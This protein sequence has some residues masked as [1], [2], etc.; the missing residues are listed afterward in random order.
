MRDAPTRT[1]TATSLAGV[2]VVLALVGWGIGAIIVGAG[3]RFDA[4][5]VNGL[6]ASPHTTV[7]SLARDAT[8]LGSP[9]WLDVVF[10]LAAALL[11]VRRQL[12]AVLFLV[13]ASPATV[14]LHA[15]IVRL[16]NR[17]RPLGPHLSSASGASFPSGHTMDST[18]LYLGLALILVG[19]LRRGPAGP[20]TAGRPRSPLER[21]LHGLVLLLLAA[22]GV[23]R[24]V[25]GVHYPSDVLAG[26]L[27]AGAWLGALVHF[28]RGLAD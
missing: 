15:V 11:L 20:P 2:W 6:R 8:F 1:R 5:V 9:L 27:I 24:V 25:V 16:V 14:A 19:V 3:S 21:I 22:I 13:L 23:S 7:L 12:R 26:W 10:L 28:A 4:S 18:G 17:P